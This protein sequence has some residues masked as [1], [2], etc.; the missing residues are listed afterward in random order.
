MDIM[1]PKGSVLAMVQHTH[2]GLGFD[3]LR[4]ILLF[5]TRFLH[6]LVPSDEL[7]ALIRLR[8]GLGLGS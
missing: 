2:L 4:H 3:L 8:V 6:F 1:A 7:T 5:P